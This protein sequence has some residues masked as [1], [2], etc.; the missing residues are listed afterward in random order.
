MR[1]KI[2]VF[3]EMLILF[4]KTLM[5]TLYVYVIFYCWNLYIGSHLQQAPINSNNQI[6]IN[7]TVLIE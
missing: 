5:N 6:L 7:T 4:M 2:W 3:F 1:Q